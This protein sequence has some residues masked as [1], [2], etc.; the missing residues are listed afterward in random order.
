MIKADFDNNR[1]T[2]RLNGISRM[3]KSETEQAFYQI[4]KDLKQ[5]AV[6]LI[7]DKKKKTGR[8][9]I[10]RLNGRLVRHRA[11]APGEA[12]ANFTGNL[13]KSV[14]YDVSGSDKLIFGAGGKKSKVHYA[15]FLEQGTRKMQPRPFLKKAIEDNYRNIENHIKTFIQKGH[16]KK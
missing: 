12:P 10:K 5:T 7:A 6:K 2:L 9:Y 14:G 8:I 13:K 4:G 16:S 3:L 11:S 1:V 15:K